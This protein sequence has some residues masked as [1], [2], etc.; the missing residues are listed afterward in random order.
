MNNWFLVKSR[1]T[2]NLPIMNELN[3]Y[4]KIVGLPNLEITAVEESITKLVLYGHFK[5]T[6]SLCPTCLQPT[7]KINQL[8]VRK[9]RDLKISGREVW[10]HISVP[11]FYCVT[12]HRYFFSHPEWMM[13][14]KSYTRRQAKWIFEMCEKQAFTQVAAL[15]NMQVKTVN[16]LF[17]LLAEKIVNLPQRYAQVRQLG[18]DEVAH[19]KGKA[20]YVCVLTDLERGIQLDVLPDRHKDTLIAHFQSLGVKFC[21]QIQVVACDMWRPYHQVAQHCFPHAQTVVD[22]FHVVKLL[23]Q[24]VDTERKKLRQAEPTEINYKQIK[25]L[26]FKP[27]I[28]CNEDNKKRL[29][30]AFTTS[31]L[32]DKLYQ[33]RES[34]NRLFDESEHKESLKSSLNEW[35]YNAQLSGCASLIKFTK[36]LVNWQDSIAAFADGRV[37]NAVTEGLNNY[38]R[39][40]QRISYGL[41]NFKNMRMRIL[42]ASA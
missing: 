21:Q 37:T 42:V 29:A 10:L 23:N 11:Q 28:A 18:I 40:M 20:S 6:H 9:V 32:L 15:E 8:D 4:E 22:R 24:V 31:P 34:F 12:C 39:Y 41:S 17:Y 36:T 38:L 7:G 14:G 26:L 16:R 1:G 33:L 3:F 25:W 5:K 30:Q 2:S 19:R 27:N 13:P 35:V